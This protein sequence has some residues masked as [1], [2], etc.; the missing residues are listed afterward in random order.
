MV[1]EEEYKFPDGRIGIKSYSDMGFKI[2]DKSDGEVYDYA[3]DTIPH[4]YEETDEPIIE[5][6]EQSLIENGSGG[7]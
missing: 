2:M 5:M 4:E 1:Q 7:D 6:R 3:V